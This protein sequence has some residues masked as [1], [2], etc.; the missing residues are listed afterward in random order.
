[1]CHIRQYPMDGFFS[2]FD[3]M[4]RIGPHTHTHRKSMRCVCECV[5]VDIRIFASTQCST[6]HFKSP[7][8]KSIQS[9]RVAVTARINSLLGSFLSQIYATEISFRLHYFT[10]K[11][12]V[13]QSEI[14]L[15]TNF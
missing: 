12:V 3:C 1:M 7:F 2:H 5:C 9:R 6:N 11:N 15:F 10:S 8:S 14:V 4:R 13:R